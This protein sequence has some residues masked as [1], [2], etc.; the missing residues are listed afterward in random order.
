[1]TST[2]LDAPPP[3]PARRRRPL[4]KRAVHVIRRGHLYCGLFLLPWVLL[5]VDEENRP[6][7]QLYRSLGFELWES[8]VMY[9]RV[10]EER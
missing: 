2:E 4:H 3:A 8:D 7:V 9:G 6:A 5:Y 1:M 10:P